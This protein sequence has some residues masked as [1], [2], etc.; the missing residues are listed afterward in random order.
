M[1]IGGFPWGCNGINFTSTSSGLGT[2]NQ[3]TINRI[4]FKG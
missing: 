4:S 2:G 1:D 3:N